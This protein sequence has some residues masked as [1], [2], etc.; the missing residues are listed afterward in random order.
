[1]KNKD[2]PKILRRIIIL[3]LILRD[4]GKIKAILEGFIHGILGILGENKKYL[5]GR[6]KY[7]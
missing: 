1:M 2:F 4:K 5:P 7:V 3:S 6:L